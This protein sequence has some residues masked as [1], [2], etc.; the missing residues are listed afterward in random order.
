MQITKWRETIPTIALSVD[1]IIP[2]GAVAAAVGV[3][4]GED[5]IT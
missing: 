5:V 2:V 3:E 4:R 1:P